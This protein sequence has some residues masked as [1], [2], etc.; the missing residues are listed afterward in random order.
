MWRISIRGNPN[1]KKKEDSK[2]W[3]KHTN[4]LMMDSVWWFRWIILGLLAVNLGF[5][6]VYHTCHKTN[7][8][9]E[10]GLGG[11]TVKVNEFV[12]MSLMLQL[13][14]VWKSGYYTTA[15]VAFLFCVIWPYIRLHMLLSAWVLPW[16]E[17][18]RAQLLEWMD[19]LGKWSFLEFLGSV[20]MLMAMRFENG[21]KLGDVEKFF[22]VGFHLEP[23]TGTFFSFA[24]FFLSSVVN[25][26]ILWCHRHKQL[27]EHRGKKRRCESDATYDIGFR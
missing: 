19:I 21:M 2:T 8:N 15:I 13:G 11:D 26:W 20:V 14:A 5:M 22:T 25:S 17:R 24:A 12:G 1:L 16:E 7:I 23:T 10:F 3:W 6:I 18:R 9:L 27:E 4:V